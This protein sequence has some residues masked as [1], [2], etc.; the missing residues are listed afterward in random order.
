MRDD[1][2]D[3]DLLALPTPSRTRGL[4]GVALTVTVMILSLGL[5]VLYRGDLRYFFFADRSPR[6]LG[7]A[8]Q[9]S[10]GTLAEDEY[11]TLRAMP[12][13]ARAVRF[14]RLGSSGVFRVYPVAGQSRIL[15]ERFIEDGTPA[16][17]A[18]PHGIYTGRMVRMSRAGSAYKSVR[19]YL[20]QQAGTPVPADAWVLIDGEAPGDRYWTVAMYAMLLFFFGFNAVILVRN[21]RKIADPDAGEPSSLGTPG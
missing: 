5:M 16:G 19:A 14:R 2:L 7:A 3:A 4:T 9:V 11:V 18:K 1:E 12:M 13:A 10:V 17:R 15:V 21:T 8:D 6:D 20:E